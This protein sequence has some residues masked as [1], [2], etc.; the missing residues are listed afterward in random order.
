MLISF[1]SQFLWWL[2]WTFVSSPRLA[3]QDLTHNCPSRNYELPFIVII[4][5]IP[6]QLNRVEQAMKLWTKSLYGPCSTNWAQSHNV[7]LGFYFDRGLEDI[8]EAVTNAKRLTTQG[9]IGDTIRKCFKGGVVYEAAGLGAK[10]TKN[11]HGMDLLRNLVQ[12]GG[13]NRMFER[14]FK[15]FGGGKWRHFFYMEPDVQPIRPGWL[16]R[17]EEES[18]WGE[19]W[20]RG[21]VMRYSSRFNIGWEPWRSMY[22]RHLNGNGIYVLDDKCFEKYRELVRKEYGNGAFDVAMT[23]YR[24]KMGNLGIYKAVASRFQVTE[25]VADM[26]VGVF[27]EEE[28]REKM[29]RVYLVHGKFMHV[30]RPWLNFGQY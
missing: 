27:Q 15:V 6:S 17:V 10:E 11:E 21:T 16:E 19:F 30:K 22:Q 26:G 13:S 9:D 18:R 25:V 24:L 4:P 23:Y 12:T 2:R 20:M 29:P 1:D 3:S 8:S 5:L 28:V 14:V 7:T